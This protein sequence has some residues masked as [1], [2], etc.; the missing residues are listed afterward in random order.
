MGEPFSFELLTNAESQVR[1]DL[2]VMVQ[3]H[4]RR[5]GVDVRTR[6]GDRLGTMSVDAF[7]ERAMAEIRARA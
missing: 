1:V 4:L 3:E 7:A 5:I 2:L 6:A